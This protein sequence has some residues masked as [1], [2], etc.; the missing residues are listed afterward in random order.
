MLQASTTAAA[1][2]SKMLKNRRRRDSTYSLLADDVEDIHTLD[3]FI[4]IF[5]FYIFISSLHRMRSPFNF[6]FD[7][8]AFFINLLDA[9]FSVRSHR[10]NE[11][12]FIVIAI[13]ITNTYISQK[14]ISF[15]ISDAAAFDSFVHVVIW[16]FPWLLWLFSSSPYRF[17]NYVYYEWLHHVAYSIDHRCSSSSSSWD[18]SND[19]LLIKMVCTMYT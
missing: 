7:S 4:P 10:Q 16:T 12:A 9:R 19:I 14:Q 11:M 15:I 5:I 3:R 8:L 13:V 18:S 1:K 17:K 6:D 2:S